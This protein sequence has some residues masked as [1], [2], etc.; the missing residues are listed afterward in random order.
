LKAWYE[1]PS[2]VDIL[3]TFSPPLR[4]SHKP[5]R[6]C[7]Y[8]Q[9]SQSAGSI[10]GDCVSVKVESGIIKEKDEVLLMP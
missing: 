3:D 9:Y 7:I 6:I 4:N 2:L 1:G 8:D 5:L 10:L